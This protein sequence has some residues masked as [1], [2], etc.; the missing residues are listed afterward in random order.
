MFHIFFLLLG[1]HDPQWLETSDLDS[2]FMAQMWKGG[3]GGRKVTCPKS[4]SR[5][6]GG[7]RLGPRSSESPGHNHPC[8]WEEP[9]RKA[10]GAN[11]EK[12]SSPEGK[13]KAAQGRQASEWWGYQSEEQGRCRLQG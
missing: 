9:W 13:R 7:A 11:A 4:F 12:G 5:S 6:V 10:T 3:P 1:M 8:E 2:P